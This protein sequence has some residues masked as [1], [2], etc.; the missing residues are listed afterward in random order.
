MTELISDHLNLLSQ[1]KK[2]IKNVII[3]GSPIEQL[4]ILISNTANESDFRTQ[5]NVICFLSSNYRAIRECEIIVEKLYLQG[6][7]FLKYIFSS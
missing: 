1:M 6:K 4:V 7:Q 2:A 5:L 3:T